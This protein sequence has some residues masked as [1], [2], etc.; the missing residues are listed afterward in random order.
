MLIKEL[1]ES[2]VHNV[3]LKFWSQS[4]K[5]ALLKIVH[6][7]YHSDKEFSH[8]EEN[9]F[10]KKLKSLDV[11]ID[12]IN[13]LSID[14]ATT[15]L[16]ADKVKKELMY[17]IIAEAIF[18]D[19]DYDKMEKSFVEGLI[20]KYGIDEAELKEHI[21]VKRNKLLNDVLSDWVKEIDEG[22]HFKTEE[23]Q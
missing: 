8:E 21:K 9:D 6:E 14:D 18:K 4:E 22:D 5:E 23:A 19:E 20:G 12:N 2:A 3:V 16:K 10:N 11:D 17:I 7:I 13:K 1:F 15:I